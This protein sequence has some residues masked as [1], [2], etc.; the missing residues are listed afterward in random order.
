MDGKGDS[1][2]F[3]EYA[4]DFVITDTSKEVL[5][6]EIKPQLVRYLQER[7]L[8]LCKENAWYPYQCSL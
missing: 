2:K 5:I 7:G 6:N 3:I 8:I 1:I 4:D